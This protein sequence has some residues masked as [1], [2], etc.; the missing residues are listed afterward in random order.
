ME[1]GGVPDIA[2]G[3]PDIHVAHAEKATRG[4]SLGCAVEIS[5]M[6]RDE[7]ARV[8]LAAVVEAR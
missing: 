1:T 6:L 4:P 3:R 5:D 2:D 7:N 8:E